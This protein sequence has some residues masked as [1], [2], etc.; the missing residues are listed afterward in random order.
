MKNTRY[1]LGD[2]A[3]PGDNKPEFLRAL[4]KWVKE[5]SGGKIANSEKFT[6]SSQTSDAF[7]RTLLC[8]A[9]LIEDL[10]SDGFKF[11]LTARFQSDPLERRYGQYR[12]MS[13]GR[14]LVSLKDVRTSEKILKIKSLVK[15]GFDIDETVKTSDSL[16]SRI[17]ELMM[18]FEGTIL[19]RSISFKLQ[20]SSKD[21]SNH[22]AGYI[23]KKIHAVCCDKCPAFLQTKSATLLH[24][25][26]DNAASYTSV[27]SRGGLT[28]ACDE[29]QDCVAQS[30]AYL[31]A[32]STMICNS[33]VPARR[34]GQEIL[35]ML[36][37]RP[38]VF[39]DTHH[40]Q[41]SS[42]V[43]KIILNVF[44]NN[45]RKQI[46]DSVV[47]DRVASFKKTKREKSLRGY[48]S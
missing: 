22:I 42:R 33:S 11:V 36:P 28:S 40:I 2:A 14:F 3:A 10:L 25:T 48:S 21:I 18:E 1:S 31:D 24:N 16:E 44:F 27:L 20:D 29:L 43:D 13:G 9:S 19:S 5:W 39:C 32:S 41:N 4:A 34:A 8:Q 38:R 47:N 35:K 30:F 26:P 37:C 45:K 17:L 12:Q 6:L 46:S 7:Q 23:S 15:E